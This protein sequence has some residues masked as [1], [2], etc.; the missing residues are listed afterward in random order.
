MTGMPQLQH[1]PM[2]WRAQMQTLHDPIG[3][4]YAHQ[5]EIP[6]LDEYRASALD[7]RVLGVNPPA[8]HDLG[9]LT[10]Q[11]LK[12]GIYLTQWVDSA[13]PASSF[14]SPTDIEP[15]RSIFGF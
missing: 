4:R 13:L 6:S 11:P 8:L 14:T 7:I 12:E 5:L 3:P 9:F 10:A 2:R 1:N 15:V